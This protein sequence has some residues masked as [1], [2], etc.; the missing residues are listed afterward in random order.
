IGLEDMGKPADAVA[1]GSGFQWPAVMRGF[2]KVSTLPYEEVRA[3]MIRTPDGTPGK[4]EPLF[5]GGNPSDPHSGD[6]G[7]PVSCIDCHA[8][9]SMA[10]RVTRPGFVRGI[11]AL[12]AG[13]APTPHLPSIERWRQGNRKQPYDPNRDATRQELRSFVCGQCHV[14]YYCGN[15]MTLT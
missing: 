14:E 12:A 13:D 5:A 9:D 6:Q 7:H 4:S 2:E 8:P 10:I 3:E 1:L 11:Q 15:K